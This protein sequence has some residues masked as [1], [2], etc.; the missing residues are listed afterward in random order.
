[1][2]D[3]SSLLCSLRIIYTDSKK[4]TIGLLQSHKC[5]QPWAIDLVVLLP[6]VFSVG[7]RF[8]ASFCYFYYCSFFGVAAGCSR[9]P[10]S[11]SQLHS[12]VTMH[13]G[14]HWVESDMTTYSICLS[15]VPYW[16]S[17]VKCLEQENAHTRILTHDRQDS[18]T[19]NIKRK[20]RKIT[21]AVLKKKP[22]FPH[23]T[24]QLH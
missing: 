22:L 3:T 5:A 16:N 6:L 13:H 8:C 9:S 14:I 2:T 17:S 7:G 23:A 12:F 10:V 24:F 21:E 11:A 15:L 1:M 19:E 18:S 4:F 20:A